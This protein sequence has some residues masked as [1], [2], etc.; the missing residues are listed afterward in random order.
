MLHP[1]LI[2]I[3]DDSH[4]CPAKRRQRQREYAR[5]AL[6]ESAQL[7]AAPLDGYRQDESDVPLPNNGFYWSISHKRRL[8]AGIVSREPIGIDV[9]HVVP[10]REGLFEMV[11]SEEEWSLLGGRTWE[12][13]YRLFTAKEA[14]LKANGKGIGY[15]RE[16]RLSGA[17]GNALVLSFGDRVLPVILQP[18]GAHLAAACTDGVVEWTSI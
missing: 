2:A 17:A 1:V 9:E 18:F 13:F 11:G 7:S 14:T 12:N 4:L 3:P 10:R 15:L 6:R 8:A 16:T 5:I